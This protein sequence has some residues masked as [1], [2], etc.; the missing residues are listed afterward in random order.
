MIDMLLSA[1]TIS[2]EKC[3]ASEAPFRLPEEHK[4]SA[5]DGSEALRYEEPVAECMGHIKIMI[6]N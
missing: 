4:K 2:S 5:S 6:A 1:R 3:V